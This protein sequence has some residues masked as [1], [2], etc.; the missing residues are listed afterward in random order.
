[1]SQVAEG[2]SAQTWNPGHKHATPQPFADIAESAS[3][4]QHEQ[5]HSHAHSQSVGVPPSP[6][7]P[8]P[9]P[10]FGWRIF[11]LGAVFA[12]LLQFVVGWL[13]VAPVWERFFGRFVWNRGEREA[14]SPDPPAFKASS[15][16]TALV[17]Y[18]DTAESVEWVN[19]CWRKVSHRRWGL[20]S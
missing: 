5:S 14:A 6:P 12:V 13:A 3:A 9:P 7:T 4:A 17:L 8:Q 16:S 20:R 2:T 18:S 1:M 10:K 19:M 11:G 15:K